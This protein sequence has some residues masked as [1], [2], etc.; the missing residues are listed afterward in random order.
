MENSEKRL[1][2]NNAPIVESCIRTSAVQL[3]FFGGDG[4]GWGGGFGGGGTGFGIGGLPPFR[5]SVRPLMQLP[6]GIV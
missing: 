6:A 5:V 3:Y 2:P 4:G 1:G